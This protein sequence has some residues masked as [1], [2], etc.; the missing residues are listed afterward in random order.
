VDPLPGSNIAH[1]EQSDMPPA[2]LRRNG[3]HKPPREPYAARKGDAGTEGR[4]S[5]RTPRLRR[6]LFG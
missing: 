3:G 2:E 5:S 1:L 4:P 6:Q